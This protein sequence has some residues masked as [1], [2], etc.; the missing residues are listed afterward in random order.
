MSKKKISL[1][2]KVLIGLLLGL[3]TGIIVFQLPNGVV[4][5]KILIDGVFQLVGQMFLRAIMMLVV[6]LVFVSLVNG[7]ASMG[8][9]KKLGRVG[10]KTV[11]FY[12]TTTALAVIIALILGFFLKPGVGLDMSAIETV[13]PIINEKV[14]LIQI[15]YEMVPRNPI[16]AMAEGNMLQ[17]IVFA[18]L[19]GVGLSLLGKKA[20]LLIKLFDN[21][22]DL[23]MKLVEIVMKFA[24]IGVFGLI[25]RTFAT[26]G[27]TGLLP[28]IKYILTVYLG[29]IIHMFFIYGGLLKGLTN[30]SPMKFYKKFF[31]AMSVAFS[32]ASSN[33]TVPVSLEI[34]EK[35]LGISKNIASFTIP[36]GATIN[37]DG[38]AIMQGIAVFF[39][40]QVYGYELTTGMMLTVILT[41]TLA[42]IGTAGVPGAGTIM[43][44]MVLQSIGLPLEGIGLI[45]GI[46]RLV[47]MGRTVTNITGDAVCTAVIAKQEGELNMEVAN[48]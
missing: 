2:S 4:K 38:T 27:Y 37:M 8:D 24:P 18:I 25:A 11:G 26:V 15:L 12:L 5:D 17:I 35:E 14:P 23:I 29:L 1:T 3:I 34:A 13:D 22:N 44:S 40:A 31:P 33:A 43:L 45:M 6:P 42:S 47:D 32:T 19:T 7:A 21:L 48:S 30:L 20:E 41:A 39:I 9:V 36:L 46:D 16:A 28:L 10:V